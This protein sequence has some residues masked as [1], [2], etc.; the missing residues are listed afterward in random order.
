MRCQDIMQTPVEF[1]RDFETVHV[2]ARKMA[3]AGVGFLPICDDKDHLVGVLTD[4]DITVRLA[5]ADRTASETRVAEVMTRDVIACR[6]DDPVGRA[7][8]LMG[9]RHVS[10]V[11][12]M[13][14]GS[15]LVGLIS[16]HDL[17][18]VDDSR[19]AQTLRALSVR[20]IPGV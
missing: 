9:E 18:R 8:E 20:P 16:V 14:H 2:A 7:L 4:R 13:T 1:C 17:G 5:A 11:L 15:V 10:R 3:D 19:V 12:V 6:P